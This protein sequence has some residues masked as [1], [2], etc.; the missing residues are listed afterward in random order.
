MTTPRELLKVTDW[1]KFAWFLYLKL[2]GRRCVECS[3]YVDYADAD[4]YTL[5]GLDNE[6][7][8]FHKACRQLPTINRGLVKATPHQGCPQVKPLH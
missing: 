1:K 2:Y 4:I 6:I 7:V 8:L 3:N 5:E